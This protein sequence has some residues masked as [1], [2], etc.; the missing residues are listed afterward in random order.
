MTD[1]YPYDALAALIE[2]ERELEARDDEYEAQ[3]WELADLYNDEQRLEDAFV[4][5]E[6][7]L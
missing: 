1:R 3:L 2:E 7:E 5:R 6:E 4:S